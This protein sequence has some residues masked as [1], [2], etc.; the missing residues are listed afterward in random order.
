MT[1]HRRSLAVLLASVAA[2]A[3]L[4]AR[5]VDRSPQPDS[6]AP[7]VGV[8]GEGAPPALAA[9]APATTGRSDDD[10]GRPG[11]AASGSVAR[12]GVRE[13]S[14]ATAFS[15]VVV[16]ADGRPIRGAV[17]SRTV[18]ASLGGGLPSTESL[19]ATDAEGR[20]TLDHDGQVLWVRVRA[21]GLVQP[22]GEAALRRGVEER[23]RLVACAVVRVRVVD[24]S[25]GAASPDASVWIT[26]GDLATTVFPSQV[27]APRSDE[28]RTDADGRVT[29]ASETGR[30]VLYVAPRRGA[31]TSQDLVIEPGGRDV[32]VRV[33]PGGRV[34]GQVFDANEAPAPRAW[35]RLD[36]PPAYRREVLADEA[37]RFAFD[38]VPDDDQV[39]ELAYDADP[40][41]WIVAVDASRRARGWAAVTPTPAGSVARVTVAL[42]S[43]AVRGQVVDANG[44][45]V[46]GRTVRARLMMPS[47]DDGIPAIDATT[48]AEGGYRIDGAAPGVWTVEV[49]GDVEGRAST[50][51]A[52]EVLARGEVVAP[53][54][55]LPERTGRLRFRL[56]DAAGL[57]IEGAQVE[58][59]GQ[60]GVVKGVERSGVTDAGGR[61]A[62]D[63][64]LVEGVTLHLRVPAST[65]WLVT[66]ASDDLRSASDV[67]VR[68]PSGD[69][70]G[71]AT[72]LDG[73]PARVRLRLGATHGVFIDAG[74]P[75]TPDVDGRFRFRGIAAD[76]APW[77]EADEEDWMALP[78]AMTVRPGQDDLR[79]ILVTREEAA[80]LH[81]RLRV[82]DEAGA[83]APVP[84]DASV[85]LAGAGSSS[86]PALTV[87]A[88]V[89]A[90]GRF[91]S[92]FP[93]PPGTYTGVLRVRGYR[94]ARIESLRL[95]SS[96]SLPTVQLV[97]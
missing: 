11:D 35:V 18:V 1:T 77:I 47:L 59:R 63:G 14:A 93:L 70:A 81:V 53:D 57:P 8:A 87:G 68:L 91:E 79:I 75:L 46:A 64:V 88:G 76:H 49:L 43:A 69:C 2:V 30:A 26:S 32:E 94:D 15:L 27:G 38:D 13:P 65:W 72:R 92:A 58:V 16:A 71:R 84:R 96:D 51:A 73:S 10:R 52:V 36:V 44:R 5:G 83:P 67:V 54:L 12:D 97:R 85:E 60:V 48:D 42:A 17:V 78:H 61:V 50:S 74:L 6:G 56:L 22:D 95:P 62:V 28:G 45:P 31:A 80:G 7:A 89:G 19:G 39:Q 24:A 21:P 55:V 34:E 40:L 41:A 4:L 9:A 82:V 25:T 20:L 23:I 90:D 29:L 3:A 37:G 86:A 33:G 66:V